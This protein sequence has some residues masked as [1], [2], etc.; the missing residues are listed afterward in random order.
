MRTRATGLCLA[1]AT[2]LLPA[3]G[4]AADHQDGPA[5]KADPASDITDIFSWMSS[6]T[7]QV[8][9]V[10]DVFPAATAASKFSNTTQ[11]VF[12]TTAQAGYG[13][14][15][16]ASNNV[17]CTFDTTQK[18]SCWAGSSYVTGD[19]S[20]TAGITSSDSKV[21]VFAGL[22]DDPFFFNLT[23]FKDAAADAHANAGKLTFDTAGC[24]DLS[25]SPTGSSLTYQQ[26]LFADL[27][28]TGHGAN[29]PVDFFKGLNVLSIVIAVDKTVLG[30][31]AT[32]PIL[33]VWGSTNH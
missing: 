31:S 17:I 24:P 2:L 29:P 6:D 20:S 30:V 28:H 33:G 19:A 14:A 26:I 12:H 27:T 1:L 8:Y 5:V 18:I 10:M 21:K 9:L 32:S 15:P 13:M 25:Q 16:T 4:F 23:G 11:Y 7:N 22:R 3:I